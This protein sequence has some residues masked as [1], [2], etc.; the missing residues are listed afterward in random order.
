[1]LATRFYCP[2]V[3]DDTRVLKDNNADSQ[4]LTDGLKPTCTQSDIL[5]DLDVCVPTNVMDSELLP[6]ATSYLTVIIMIISL[7]ALQ[8]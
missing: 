2:T 7:C 6:I 3:A 8:S 1:M 4:V 5:S